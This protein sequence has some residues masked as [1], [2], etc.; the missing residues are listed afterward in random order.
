MV[1]GFMIHQR[2]FGGWLE[3]TV[4]ARPPVLEPGLQTRV[5]PELNTDPSILMGDGIIGVEFCARLHPAAENYQ[6]HLKYYYGMI[7]EIAW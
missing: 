2:E 7:L 1:R 5:I 3:Y 6:T 4:S